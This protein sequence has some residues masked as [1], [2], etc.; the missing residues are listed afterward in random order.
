MPGEGTIFDDALE[1]TAA[2]GFYIYIVVILL[3]VVLCLYTLWDF[4]QKG[5]YCDGKRARLLC[6]SFAIWICYSAAA[7]IDAWDR[8]AAFPKALAS[9]HP[10]WSLG[11]WRCWYLCRGAGWM[12]IGPSALFLA[13]IALGIV[14]VVNMVT[15]KFSDI[16]GILWVTFS[17]A[18]N[19]MITSIIVSKLVI[20]RQVV[21][22]SKMY[23]QPPQFYRDVIVVLVE[24]AAPLTLAGLCSIISAAVRMSGVQVPGSG[25]SLFLFDLVSRACFLLFAALSPQMI[26][27]RTLVITPRGLRIADGSPSNGSGVSQSAQFSTIQYIP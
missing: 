12:V 7:F 1:K 23:D 8:N 18:T 20:T 16:V 9:G 13:S 15:G 25:K 3:G 21:M 5:C 19:V 27:F 10:I 17:V 26:L 6:L 14:S 22:K 24:S 2:T 11:L 4:R